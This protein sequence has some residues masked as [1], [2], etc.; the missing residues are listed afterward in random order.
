MIANALALARACL[1]PCKEGKYVRCCRWWARCQCLTRQEEDGIL[2]ASDASGE[3]A[4]ITSKNR[5]RRNLHTRT[6]SPVFKQ[7][8]DDASLLAHW[9]IF[10]L[11]EHA[12]VSLNEIWILE[13]LNVFVVAR[14]IEEKHSA[15]RCMHW[16]FVLRPILWLIL[17]DFSRYWRIL[18][19]P[20]FLFVYSRKAFAIIVPKKMFQNNNKSINNSITC[21]HV[22][23]AQ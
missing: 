12:V 23:T 16:W 11:F 2:I 18:S 14:R 9:P 21:H 22:P 17:L 13:V 3:A 7:I 4:G 6:Q 5:S 10:K 19:E 20:W 15:W 1:E 8:Y